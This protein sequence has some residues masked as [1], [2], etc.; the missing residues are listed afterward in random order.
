VHTQ[1]AVA[2]DSWLYLD[3]LFV[4]AV[5]GLIVDTLWALI[6]MMV[7]V[8][9]RGKAAPAVGIAIFNQLED[10]NNMVGWYARQ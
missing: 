7:V 9:M 6:A 10:L 3:S 5:H 8:S 1:S 4:I 2:C